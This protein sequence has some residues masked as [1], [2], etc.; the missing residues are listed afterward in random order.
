VLPPLLLPAG[1]HFSPEEIVW[2]FYSQYDPSHVTSSLPAGGLHV[3]IGAGHAFG[4]PDEAAP[5]RSWIAAQVEA[6]YPLF[7]VRYWTGRTL[8]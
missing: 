4:L 3:R 5:L 2:S 1:W 6:L 8:A 7:R